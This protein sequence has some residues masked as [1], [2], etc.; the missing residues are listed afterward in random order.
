MRFQQDEFVMLLRHDDET[1]VYVFPPDKS[2]RAIRAVRDD[3]LK[4]RFPFATA[5]KCIRDILA[6]CIT[7]TPTKEDYWC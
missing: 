4:G 1:F 7:E 5:V 2:V 3:A 6:N